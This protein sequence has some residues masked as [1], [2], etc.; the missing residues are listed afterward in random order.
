MP[1]HKGS[2]LRMDLTI[3][4]LNG[5]NKKDHLSGPCYHQIIKR[6]K[7][8]DHHNFLRK[9]IP[10]NLAGKKTRIA[11]GWGLGGTAIVAGTAGILMSVFGSLTLLAAGLGVLA[12]AFILGV[13]A[14]IFGFKKSKEE[15]AED[16]DKYKPVSQGFINTGFII[17][18]VA[19]GLALVGF[20][21]GFFI[22]PFGL[23]GWIISIVAV[24]ASILSFSLGFRALKD[25]R[26]IKTKLI[27]IFGFIA[28]LIA[29]LGL[30]MLF[31]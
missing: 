22:Y 26:G 11:I 29:A 2:Q 12:F 16:A 17:S 8:E 10:K 7:Y 23:I 27:I 4:S 19:M 21:L 9:P 14:F 3:D 1:T 6:K 24:L 15:K 25:D 30:M 28:L 5:P 31:I 20:V 18:I 13:L